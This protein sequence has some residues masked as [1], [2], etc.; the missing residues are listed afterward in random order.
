MLARYYLKRRDVSELLSV[1]PDV[2]ELLLNFDFFIIAHVIPLMKYCCYYGHQCIYTYVEVSMLVSR[3]VSKRVEARVEARVEGVS[4]VCV[5]VSRLYVSRLRPMRNRSSDTVQWL[6]NADSEHKI[7]CRCVASAC[8]SSPFA[9][10]HKHHMDTTRYAWQL[11]ATAA[12]V[13]HKV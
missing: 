4:R 9:Q 3:L 6:Q 10:G 5:K 1:T 13:R 11:C 7:T 12:S 8:T 2:S